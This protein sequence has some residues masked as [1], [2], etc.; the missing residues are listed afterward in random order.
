[1]CA[2]PEC[3][4][5]CLKSAE[6]SL[7][8]ETMKLKMENRMECFNSGYCEKLRTPTIVGAAVP[9]TSGFA[10]TYPCKNVD[11]LSFIDFNGL[12]CAG[13]QGNDIWGWSKDGRDFAIMGCTNGVS[14]VEITDNVKPVVIGVTKTASVSSTW[15]DMKVFNDYVFIVSEARAHGMQVVDLTRLLTQAAPGPNNLLPADT[16]YTQMMGTVSQ[17]STHNIAINE[18]T[19]FAYLVGCKTCSGG[20]LMV[21]ISTPKNPVYAGCFSGDGYTHDTQCV[22]YTQGPDR[23]F[24]N[25]EICFALNEDTLTIVDVTNKANPVQLSRVPYYGARYTHQGWLTLDQRYLLVD[26]ELDEMYKTYDNTG[27]TVTYVWDVSDL[28]EPR[29][30]KQFL[31]PVVSIDHNQYTEDVYTYQANYASGLRIWNRM[32]GKDI[33]SDSWTPTLV[34]FF[35]VHPDSDV[36][37]FYGAWSVY[38]YFTS[39]ANRNT[40]I[41]S[42]IE[43]GL[44]VLNFDKAKHV[45]D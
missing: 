20:L 27:R 5:D 25:R 21:D 37:D 7:M 32:T 14:Y 10:G 17:Q 19:G 13:A 9:C 33:A 34:G 44:F 22:N 6:N 12:G 28:G 45:A 2:P 23:R 40:I 8:P 43:K 30:I 35:D 24:T 31:S 3:L 11:L 36:A 39:A 16:T 26:D 42:S 4:G 1:M 38:P 18:E 41:V 29:D 15:R